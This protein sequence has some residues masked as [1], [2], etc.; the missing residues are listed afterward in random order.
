MLGQALR[1]LVRAEADALLTT[2]HRRPPTGPVTSPLSQRPGEPRRRR[3]HAP[4]ERGA[5]RHR[6]RAL[7]RR[8]RRPDQR[9]LHAHPVQA[10]HAH[11]RVT[12]LEVA[13]A[14]DVPGV[15]RVLTAADV[16][17]INDAGIKHDEPLFP[18]EVMYF[19]HSVCWVLGESLEAARRGAAAIEVDYDELPAL[20][21][22]E[23]A[24][25]AESFQGARPTMARGD[26]AAGLA[27][28][29][30]RLRGRHR[31]GR[32]GALLP[33][34]ALLAGH[35]RR[36]RPGLRPV[37]H[38]APDRDPGDRRARARRAQP[39]RDRPVPADGR[40]VRRQGDAAARAR[41]GRRARR[42]ADRSPG[43]AAA[44]PSAGHDDDRQAARLPRHV[45]GRLRRRRAVHRAR[46]D[47][48]RRRRLEPRP[49]RAGALARAVPHR[50][51]LLDPR[52]T[53]ARPDR[54]DQQDLA[55]RVPRASA[56]RRG[57]S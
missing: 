36:G 2:G 42:D 45:E 29:D 8:P 18:S 30:A 19:G 33:R 28:A 57:C 17:G 9:L 12:R 40:R 43:A 11:A 31:D 25:A 24:I 1:K 37:Q 53:R 23:E 48:D 51:R 56:V 7:H 16:P 49:V 41:G 35:G 15:V 3:D 47:A 34:D 27:R 14:Y 10:P 26:A 50:Q 6:P 5:A 46:G 20:L 13:A 55:D 38:P 32:A 52:R 22:V 4:R 44:D 54:E 21:T 39:R